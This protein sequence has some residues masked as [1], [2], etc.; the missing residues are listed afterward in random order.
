M[1]LSEREVELLAKHTGGAV[2][3]LLKGITAQRK[4]KK[5]ETKHAADNRYKEAG[6]RDALANLGVALK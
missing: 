1:S 3:Q 4:E 5:K 6:V 2:E